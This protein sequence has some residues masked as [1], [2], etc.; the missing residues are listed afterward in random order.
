MQNRL[1]K[2]CIECTR[3]HRRCLFKSSDEDKCTRCDKFNLCCKFRYSGMCNILY[4]ISY[5][6]HFLRLYQCMSCSFLHLSEQGRRND[7]ALCHISEQGR[8]NYNAKSKTTHDQRLLSTAVIVS[9]DS[10]HC[11]PLTQCTVSSGWSC[12]TTANYSKIEDVVPLVGPNVINPPPSW[13]HVFA[14]SSSTTSLRTQCASAASMY[15]TSP[16]VFHR[17][18][19]RA[20]K[21]RLKIHKILREVIVPHNQFK[22]THNEIDAE[23]IVVD[24]GNSTSPPIKPPDDVLW[25]SISVNQLHVEDDIHPN[26]GL[27]YP[28]VIG[29]HPFI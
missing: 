3:T 2:N 13:V 9:S 5:S 23:I 11:N 4:Y 1:Q 16:K 25:R 12:H 20:R 19:R 8:G 6:N 24:G 21:K 10:V 17:R 22:L 27:T 29:I 28:K 26:I 14:K 15:A 7:I 18:S